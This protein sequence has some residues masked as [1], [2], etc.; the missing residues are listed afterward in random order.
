MPAM[1]K[2]SSQTCPLHSVNNVKEFKKVLRTRNN[3]LVLF[4]NDE[5]ETSDMVDMLGEVLQKVK[6]E[7]TIITVS[8][9][10]K[11][12]AKI[13]KKMKI[14]NEKQFSLKHFLNGAFHK[15]Y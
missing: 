15:D 5:N 1:A 14:S 6:G 10:D 4:K 11:D 13:C 3:I 7:A 8:C 12:G 2:T 9:A